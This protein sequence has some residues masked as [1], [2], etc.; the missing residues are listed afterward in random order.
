MSANTWA[1]I[2]GMASIPSAVLA[3]WL[4]LLLFKWFAKGLEVALVLIPDH[5]RNRAVAG[6]VAFSGKR[7]W[8]FTAWEVGVVLVVG[9][10]PEQRGRA[11]DALHMVDDQ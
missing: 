5:V 8:A 11:I 6:A 10:R 2:A 1:Y 7:V 3:W 4:I 9:Q